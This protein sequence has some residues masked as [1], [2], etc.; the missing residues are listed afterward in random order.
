MVSFDVK[1]YTF[2]ER[3]ICMIIWMINK[4]VSP[5]KDNLDD[6]KKDVSLVRDNLDDKKKDVFLVRDKI[7]D[8]QNDK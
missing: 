6:K 3:I 4:D 5:V 7:D 8:K 2:L 1:R